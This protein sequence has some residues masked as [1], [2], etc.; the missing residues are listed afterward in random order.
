MGLPFFMA[1]ACS[2]MRHTLC[3]AKL[4][5][6]QVRT[7]RSRRRLRCGDAAKVTPP[8]PEQWRGPRSSFRGHDFHPNDALGSRRLAACDVGSGPE[9]ATIDSLANA[10]PRRES[11]SRLMES[12]HACTHSRARVTGKLP[13]RC[14][15]GHART[16][17]HSPCR[18]DYCPRQLGTIMLRNTT[19]LSRETGGRRG[20]VRRG[21][22]AR[23]SR[24]EVHHSRSSCVH[25]MAH[26]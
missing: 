2:T 5:Q 3:V 1:T 7:A 9:L 14:S 4:G 10:P 19:T 12:A 24:G 16:P 11:L 8:R 23:V 25:H 18:F 6:A 22:A 13:P 17:S 21:G 15:Q 20:L 26:E